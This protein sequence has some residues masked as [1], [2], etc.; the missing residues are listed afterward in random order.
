MK[1]WKIDRIISVATLVVAFAAL[2]LVLKRPAAV[3]PTQ[4]T[5]SA[6]SNSQPASGQLTQAGQSSQPNAAASA[7]SQNSQAVQQAG[8]SQLSGSSA[9]QGASQKAQSLKT[10]QNQPQQNQPQQNTQISAD[11]LSAAIAQAAGAIP[12]SGGGQ[13]SPNSDLG[14]MPAIKDQQISF[15][16]DVVHGRFLTTIAGKDVWITISGHLGDKDGY[17]TFDPTEF[18]VGDIDV[19]VSLVNG[20]LQRQLAAQRDKMKL[21]D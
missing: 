8:A 7:D 2:I 19:P 10:Q 14:S 3:A 17:A 11:E 5:S 13:L 18:K 9:T 16:G 20:P 1:N 21:P 6:T 4:T 12:G 15:D